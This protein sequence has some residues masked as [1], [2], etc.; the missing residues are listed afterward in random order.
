[1]LIRAHLCSP[2]PRWFAQYYCVGVG[3]LLNLYICALFT[4]GTH[5]GKRYYWLSASP[6]SEEQSHCGGLKAGGQ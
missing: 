1:M 2:Q 3:D 6:L 4:K 5:N